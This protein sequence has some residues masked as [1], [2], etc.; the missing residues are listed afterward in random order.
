MTTS[1]SRGFALGSADHS[2]HRLDCLPRAGQCKTNTQVAAAEGMAA[3]HSAS[4]T[5]RIVIGKLLSSRLEC[6]PWPCGGLCNY[7]QESNRL[8]I[9]GQRQE[10]LQDKKAKDK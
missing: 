5:T 4:N 7:N 8:W 3:T 10:S 9:L 1:S 6:R 2:L